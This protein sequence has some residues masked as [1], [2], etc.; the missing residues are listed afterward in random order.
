MFS[1]LKIVADIFDDEL[2]TLSDEKVDE[3]PGLGCTSPEQSRIMLS[4]KA[5]S[6][7][8]KQVM[9]TD[10]NLAFAIVDFPNKNVLRQ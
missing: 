6:M 2:E 3:G 5:N 7:T 10:T 1:E 4:Q 9:M 8:E